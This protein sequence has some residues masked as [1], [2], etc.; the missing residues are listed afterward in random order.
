M[1]VNGTSE[2]VQRLLEEAISIFSN[3]HAIMGASGV[4]IP[5]PMLLKVVIL[6]F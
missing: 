3:G 6:K 4:R 5:V 1:A 2:H